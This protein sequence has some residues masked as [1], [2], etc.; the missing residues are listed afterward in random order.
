M[1]SWY[2]ITRSHAMVHVKL[3]SFL[4]P[5]AGLEKPPRRHRELLLRIGARSGLTGT[6]EKQRNRL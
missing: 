4:D 1:S 3:T 2:A 5:A 6:S